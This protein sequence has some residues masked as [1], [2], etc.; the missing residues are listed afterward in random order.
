M[1]LGNGIYDILNNLYANQATLASGYAERIQQYVQAGAGIG[2]LIYIFSRLALQMANNQEI[3]FLPFFRP[4]IV[5]LLIPLSGQICTALDSFGN[6]VRAVVNVKNEN[7]ADQVKQ[8][9]AL[10]QQKIE[11]KWQRIGSD[12]ET[13][14]AV[15]GGDLTEDRSGIFGDAMVDFKLSFYKF[16]E[17][18]KFQ[19]LSVL[20]NILLVL[21]Y[22]A[23]CCLL[24]LSV[25][26]RIVLR[27]GF[28]ITVA[29]SIFPGF[30]HSLA[31]WFGKYLNFALLP[32]VAAMYSSLAFGI[33]NA[34]ISSY[35]VDAAVSS[36]GIETQQPEFLGLAFIGI[37]FL[38]L[39]GYTQVPSMTAMLVSVGGVGQ[40]IQ[41]ASRTIQA[42]PARMQR[43]A[44]PISQAGSGFSSGVRT[45]GVVGGISGL[46]GGAVN[47]TKEAL[48]GRRSRSAFN[49]SV[50]QK[51]K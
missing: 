36:M 16:S 48:T 8:Q 33:C 20:Q 18:F 12:P 24:L 37:L 38:C 4:F 21:M 5:M 23:E 2:A 7:I 26:F 40:V 34:Y 9:S 27:I 3:D 10:I 51:K 45:G 41:T 35:D 30:G 11:Q 32:A 50:N 46:V 28:P 29:L 39:I 19:L 17:D 13:Y 1:E 49:P 25:A 47:G 22:V 44:Q 43:A 6:Q 15:M 31:T 14:Q 42:L